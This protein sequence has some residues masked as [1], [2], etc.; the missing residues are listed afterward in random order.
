MQFF[1]TESEVHSLRDY[2]IITDSCASLNAAEAEE[3]GVTVLPFSFIID[4]KTCRDTP[5][6]ADYAPGDF[7]RRLGE[8]A[9]CTTSAVNIGQFKEAM[10]EILC[11][12]RDILCICFSS[13]LSCTYQ[14]ACIAADELREEFREAKIRVVDSLCACRGLGMLITRTV[15]AIRTGGLDLDQAAEF[16]L[17]ERARQDHWFFVDDLNHLK[18][19]GRIS[20]AA[21]MAGT[22]LGI[23]PIMHC[24]AEGKL[25][26]S[27]KVR[28]QKAALKALTDKM[29]ELWAGPEEN[30]T[31]F[32]CHAG[33]TDYVEALTKLLT[34]RFGITDFRIDYICP[35]IGAHTG[36]G[37]V[38]LFFTGNER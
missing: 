2:S 8:G 36:C 32:I 16:V 7:F 31:I 9:D 24:D 13:A 33:C 28:G 12:G 18:R 29:A 6:H 37:T 34:E 25:T 1:S 23:K 20:A 21:A 38:G 5:D 19:G 26:A 15:Q 27:G 35:V 17:K 11:K 10:R 22:V 4:G 14:N 30:K 3:L